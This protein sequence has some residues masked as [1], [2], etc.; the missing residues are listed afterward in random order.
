MK[1]TEL[2]KNYVTLLKMKYVSERTVNVY[3]NCFDKFTS[4][5]SRVYRLTRKEI[6]RYLILFKSKYSISY[7][8]QMVSVLKILYRDVLNQPQKVKSLSCLKQSDSLQN[9]MTKK[10]VRNSINKL[11]NLKHRTILCVLYLCGLR[12]GELINI[13]LSDLDFHNKRLK[14]VKGKGMKDRYIPMTPK[15]SLMIKQYIKEYSPNHYLIQGQK[16]GKYSAS[17]VRKICKRVGINNPHLLRHSIV[18]HLIDSGDQQTQV[19]MFA[20]HKSPK[21]TQKYYH[22][23]LNSLKNLSIP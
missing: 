14:V 9:V 1:M 3:I 8:N 16:G 6:N 21:S 18:T 13:K 2:R 7:Y 23:S 19:Q 5:N 20:G 10:Q 22:L 4:N 12:V 15:L 11:N 17:S